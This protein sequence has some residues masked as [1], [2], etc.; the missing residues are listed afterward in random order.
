MTT[1]TP[2]RTQDHVYGD[3]MLTWFESHP[4]QWETLVA[5]GIRHAEF[6]CYLDVC[7]RQYRIEA[8]KLRHPSMTAKNVVCGGQSPAWQ[9]A[10]DFTGQFYARSTRSLLADVFWAVVEIFA[11]NCKA[12]KR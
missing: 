3:R 5:N 1:P 12:A 10:P 6:E 9:P 8:A 4:Q 7:E 2:N 11:P